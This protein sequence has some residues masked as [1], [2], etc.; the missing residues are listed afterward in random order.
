MT[1][2]PTLHQQPAWF[3]AVMGTGAMGILISL[4]SQVLE[5]QGFD[6]MV[7]D[8]VAIGLLWVATA[9]AVILWPR[10]F[11]RLAH[12]HELREEIADPGHGAML[13]TV[14]AGLLVLS[15]GWG[16][17]GPLTLPEPIAMWIAVVL[18]AA[19]VVISVGYSAIWATSI[20]THEVGL[21]RIHG[22]WMIPVVMPLLV[23]I[24]LVPIMHYWTNL[25]LPLLIVGFAF[26]GI[27]TMLFLAIFSMFVI[28]L[29]TQAPLPNPMSPSLWIPLAP[30]GVFGVAIIRLSQSAEA[31]GIVGPDSV[32]LAVAIA[33]MGI[34]FGLWW[35]LFAL[36]ELQRTRSNGGVIFHMG[37]WGFVF[38]IAAM[39]ISITLVGQVTE[40]SPLFGIVASVIAVGVWI[41]VSV[42]TLLS[43][44]AELSAT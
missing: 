10:Y 37:W 11:R 4:Q 38:P 7:I 24:A 39:A 19:G 34:G 22:G 16:A 8:W 6:W 21:A 31:Y 12:R 9:L 32:W 14:P 3:G 20:S 13:A 15:V 5:Q 36:L 23:P 43:V 1:G 40:F 33:V 29:A 44:I 35:A 42:K 25:T 18:V 17:I 28:R 26:L 27:G 30:A 2:M 41:L